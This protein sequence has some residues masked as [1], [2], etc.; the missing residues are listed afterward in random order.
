[1]SQDLKDDDFATLNLLLDAD[2]RRSVREAIEL[3]RTYPMPDGESCENGAFIAEICRGYLDFMDAAG[4]P[5]LDEA[6][7]VAPSEHPDA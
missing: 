5:A 6:R 1:M 2:D 3:R 7:Q 4:R